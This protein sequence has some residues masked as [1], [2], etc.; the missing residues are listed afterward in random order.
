MKTSKINTLKSKMES[1]KY[2]YDSEE[3]KIKKAN[4]KPLSFSAEI[5]ESGKYQ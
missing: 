3:E 1:V 5:N 2:N 4:P